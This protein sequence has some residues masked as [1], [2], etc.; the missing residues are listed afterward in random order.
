MSNIDPI[1]NLEAWIFLKPFL[2]AGNTREKKK[3]KQ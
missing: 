3:N 1:K 2:E